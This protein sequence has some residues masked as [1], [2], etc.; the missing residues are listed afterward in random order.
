M[1]DI[2][3]RPR[4]LVIHGPNL[5]LL[6]TREPETYGTTTLSDI[7][8]TLQRTGDSWG[9]NIDTF[10]SNH[11]GMIVEAIQAIA[12]SHHGLIINPA[13]YT[14]TSVAIRDALLL[15]KMPIVEVHLSN[16]HKREPF[17]HTSMISDVCTGQIVGL[18]SMGYLLA[19]EFIVKTLRK[20]SA[21]A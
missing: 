9:V 4:I 16:V 8:E 18:G 10:Q 14:H 15:L 19:L 3:D 21:S 7:N 1:N 13:A 11:E 6:G 20:P 5:N 17:R 12:A 2:T